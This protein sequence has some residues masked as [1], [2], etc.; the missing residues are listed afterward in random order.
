MYD[1]GPPL[2]N[3][4]SR[5]RSLRLQYSLRALAI[6]ITLFMV[7]GGYHANRGWKQRAAEAVLLRHEAAIYHGTG[8]IPQG[9]TDHVVDAY[10]SLVYALWGEGRVMEID[11]KSNMEP[12]VVEALIALPPLD[13]LAIQPRPYTSDETS[14]MYSTGDFGRKLKPP[15]GAMDRITANSKVKEVVLIA[16]ELSVDDCRALAACESIE[17]LNLMDCLLTDEGFAELLKLPRLHSLRLSHCELTEGGLN[18]VPGSKSLVTISCVAT[19]VGKEFAA[20][21]ARSGNVTSLSVAH[22]DIGDEF[23][24]K[25]GPHP[26]LSELGVHGG[27]I[28]CDPVGTKEM[29]QLLVAFSRSSGRSWQLV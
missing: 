23:I 9:F 11:I 24:R 12:E 14:Q 16:C 15:M 10:Q 1:I 7:W 25:L 27:D 5:P 19:P 3:V 22:P 2:G 17:S 4:M 8:R 21:V 13:K 20:F 26:S 28:G 6:F 29:G 18:S